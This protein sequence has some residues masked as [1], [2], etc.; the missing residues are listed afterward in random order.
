MTNFQ[1]LQC[2]NDSFEFLKSNYDRE[3]KKAVKTGKAESLH[4][5]DCIRHEIMG[6]VNGLLSA[7]VDKQEIEPIRI[8]L[9]SFY[10]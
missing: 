4:Q 9:H 10:E 6:Y 2:I 1:T 7:G 5:A 8:W 3:I